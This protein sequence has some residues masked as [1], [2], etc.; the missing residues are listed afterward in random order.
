MSTLKSINVIH[1]SSAVNNIV[2]DASGNVAVGNNL[3]VAGTA[4]VGGVAAVAVAPGTNGNVLTSNGTAWTS[5]TPAGGGLPTPS[6]IGQIPF[7]TSGS[8]YAA[9][10]K[11]V[12]GTSQASTSGTSIDFTSIP[13]WAKRVTVMF[14]GVSTSGSSGWIVQIGGSSIETTSY[15]STASWTG[16]STGGAASTAGFV[17]LGAGAG[18]ASNTLTGVMTL[19]LFDSSTNTWINQLA[20]GF[21]QGASNF[22]SQGGGSKTITGS[23]QRVRITTIGG[24]DTFD[25]GSINILYE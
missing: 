4:T 7:S 9:T 20:A 2:N 8:T 18:T 24:T 11:I 1:P 21:T 13:S 10:Q 12:Q 6:A 15:V 5:A 19:N 16:S 25:A 14:N 3:T 22:S 17:L 23:L